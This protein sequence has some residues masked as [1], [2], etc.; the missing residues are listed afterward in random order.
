MPGSIPDLRIVA[1][2]RPVLKKAWS[3]RFTL[4]LMV[5]ASVGPAL[6]LIDEVVYIPRWLYI[7]TVI[8]TGFAALASRFIP[9]KG[10]TDV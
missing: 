5:L 6:P 4:L 2:W 8:A 9:Q 10:I 3:L 7:P 1:N